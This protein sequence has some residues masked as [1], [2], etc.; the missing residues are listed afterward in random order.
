MRP[1]TRA[2]NSAESGAPT[3]ASSP[4]RPGRRRRRRQLRDEP[5]EGLDQLVGDGRRRSRCRQPR[6]RASYRRDG[7]GPTVP[8]VT[9]DH[10][11]RRLG[12][13]A[14]AGRRPGVLLSRVPPA[15][16][17]RS[18]STPAPA[19][20]TAWRCPTARPTSRAAAA[21]S[22]RCRGTVVAAAFGVFNPEVVVPC[23]ELGWQRTDAATICAR[24]HR[25]R[26]R[27]AAADPRRRARRASIGPTSCSPAPSSRCARRA[28]RCSPGCAALGDP[29]RPAGGDVAARR[30]AARVPR[31]QPHRGVGVGRAR[32]H[33][34][35]PAHRAVL[36]PAAALVQPHPGV[37]RRAVR[38]RDRAPRVRVA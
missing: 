35:R 26:H 37:D 13:R 19:R 23:V 2:T 6:V 11:A 12:V 34:D 8:P 32:R 38:R 5:V 25:R 10:P 9:H 14:R 30:H 20:S 18:A 1:S 7:V 33:R 4:S 24:P 27:P 36:G 15:P 28:A 16:T 31:R 17:R 3:I 22:A 29:R 21:C